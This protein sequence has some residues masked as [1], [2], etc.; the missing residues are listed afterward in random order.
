MSFP[1]AILIKILSAAWVPCGKI[2]LNCKGGF[3]GNDYQ[4]KCGN[5]Q[6]QETS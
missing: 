5:R 2:S 6:Q 1:S 3:Q 4:Q